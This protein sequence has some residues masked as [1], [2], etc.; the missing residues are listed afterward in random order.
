M[1]A[2]LGSAAVLSPVGAHEV[3]GTVKTINTAINTPPLAF[4]DQIHRPLFSDTGVFVGDRLRVPPEGRLSIRLLDGSQITLGA[5]SE[6]T[7]EEF[8]YSELNQI[9]SLQLH[10]VKGSLHFNPGGMRRVPNFPIFLATPLATIRTQGAHIW[11][12][13]SDAGLTIGMLEGTSLLVENDGGRVILNKAG[14]V[15]QISDKTAPPSAPTPMGGQQMATIIGTVI[16]PE[17]LIALVGPG[18]KTPPTNLPDPNADSRP[19]PRTARQSDQPT[20][21]VPESK[22]MTRPGAPQS[23]LPDAGS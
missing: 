17:T 12:M 2:C 10:L 7:L 6:A 15:T 22:P 1:V 16:D 14:E 11:A 20:T 9:G 8:I 5:E 23:L 18:V 19:Q 4:S 13:L 3:I 21:P